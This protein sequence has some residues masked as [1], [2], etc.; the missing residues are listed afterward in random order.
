[1]NRG[2]TRRQYRDV[3]KELR[4]RVRGLAITTD[5]IVGFP[6]ETEEEFEESLHLYRRIGFDSAF[7]FAYSPR[8]GTAAA[9]RRDGVP[10]QIRLARLRK[11]IAVQN[12]ITAGRNLAEVGEEREVLVDGPAARGE[13]LLAGRTRTAKLVIFAGEPELRGRLVRVVL[14]EAHLWGFRGRLVGA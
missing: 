11:L 5:I 4:S 1:M 9:A 3:V 6:G 12:G 13:G 8:P 10:R 2:Y 7:T 14:T